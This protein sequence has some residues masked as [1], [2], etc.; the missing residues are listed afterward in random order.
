MKSRTLVSFDWAIKKLLRQKANFDILEGFLNELIKKDIKIKRILESQS[1]KD[2]E[3]DKYN[4][5]DLLCENEENEIVLIELQFYSELDYFQR[6]LFGVSKVITEYIS[7]SE[8]YSEIKKVYSINILY[9]DLGHGIDYIYHGSTS[10]KGIHEN[11]ILKLSYKQSERFNKKLPEEIFPEIYLLKIN[12]F[13]NIARD[14]LDEWIY[15]L[16]NTE[17]PENYTAKGLKEVSK[18]L[19]YEDMDSNTKIQYDAYNKHLMVSK[20]MI[21]TALLE[22]EK[23]GIEKGIEKGELKNQKTVIFAML[24]DGFKTEIIAKYIGMNE[25]EVIK[26]INKDK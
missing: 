5:V 22:G 24:K 20:S 15:F 25:E 6:I 26:I 21:E 4:Q 1:N 14:T 10:F 16:K 13:N 19:K 18:K 2:D 17:L 12:N 8:A 9:F 23:K 11:D 3:F 7:E